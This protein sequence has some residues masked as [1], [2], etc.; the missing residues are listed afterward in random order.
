MIPKKTVL[1]EKIIENLRDDFDGM[2]VVDI[3]KEI[4]VNVDT[5]RKFLSGSVSESR[6]VATACANNL[7]GVYLNI[8]YHIK[9]RAVRRKLASD[10]IS[11]RDA[12]A[13]KTRSRR[14]LKAMRPY[15]LPVVHPQPEVHW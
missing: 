5:L 6:V 15:L 8:L 1:Y 2:T 13:K 4:C 14:A 3:A 11:K 10:R 7:G 9:I 12:Y